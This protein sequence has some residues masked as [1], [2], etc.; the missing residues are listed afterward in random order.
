MKPLLQ[1]KLVPTFRLLA[2]FT[3]EICWEL[4]CNNLALTRVTLSTDQGPI[5]AHVCWHHRRIAEQSIE[6]PL[7]T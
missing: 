1:L 5:V 3:A 7:G 4:S 2:N 6:R